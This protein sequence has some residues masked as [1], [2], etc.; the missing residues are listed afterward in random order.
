MN[1][2]TQRCAWCNHPGDAL[3]ECSV[4]VW[5]PIA[6]KEETQTLHVHPE[7]EAA[8]RDYFARQRRSSGP[9]LYTVLGVTLLLAVFGNALGPLI[10]R[11]PATIGTAVT[12]SIGSLI[13][14]LGGLLFVYPLPT[15]ATLKALGIRRSVRVARIVGAVA[16]ALGG[17]VV[18][19]GVGPVL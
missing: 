17:W 9:V 4:R 18:S 13:V 3:R 14:V 6:A 15:D 19:L 16:A 1:W 10:E 5:K 12:V 7:H 8:V 11:L 2:P